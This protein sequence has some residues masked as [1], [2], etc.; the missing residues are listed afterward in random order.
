MPQSAQVRPV[1]VLLP[2]GG[3]GRGLLP[4]PLGGAGH[5]VQG[6][7]R[8]PELDVRLRP[9]GAPLHLERVYYVLREQEHHSDRPPCR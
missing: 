8:L 3:G 1:R 6:R 7:E 4:L 5:E 2:P 9:D